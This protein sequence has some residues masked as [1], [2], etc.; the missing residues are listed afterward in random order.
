[1]Q[2]PPSLRSTK[3]PPGAPQESAN[4]AARPRVL[5]PLVS[6]VLTSLCLGGCEQT[7]Q[8]HYTELGVCQ[9]MYASLAADV[10]FKIA[11]V[12]NSK[13]SS[14]WSLDLS[15]FSVAPWQTAN[16]HVIANSEGSLSKGTVAIPAGKV[17]NN[18]NEVVSIRTGNTGAAN[19]SDAASQSIVLLYLAAPVTVQT[20]ND[21]PMA[22]YPYYQQDACPASWSPNTG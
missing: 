20:V 12:D 15:Q 22:T 13:T 11:S 3:R 16:D 18:I 2:R 1:M 19:G 5:L 21:S 17:V 6:G 10:Y 14:S 9:D 7:A 8:L 4:Q